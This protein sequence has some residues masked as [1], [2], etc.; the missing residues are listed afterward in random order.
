MK[1]AIRPSFQPSAPTGLPPLYD[2]NDAR[3]LWR[4]RAPANDNLPIKPLAPIV[5]GVM[6]EAALIALATAAFVLPMGA[7]AARFLQDPQKYLSKRLARCGENESP[8]GESRPHWERG[9]WVLFPRYDVSSPLTPHDRKKIIE[10]LYPNEYRDPGPSSVGGRPFAMPEDPKRVDTGALPWEQRNLLWQLP[11]SDSQPAT[12]RTLSHLDAADRMR[13]SPLI[14]GSPHERYLARDFLDSRDVGDKPIPVLPEIRMQAAGDGDRNKRNDAKRF[15]RNAPLLTPEQLE[16]AANDLLPWLATCIENLQHIPDPVAISVLELLVENQILTGNSVTTL[17]ETALD[18]MTGPSDTARVDAMRLYVAT[19]NSG[20]LTASQVEAGVRKMLAALGEGSPKARLN[21]LWGMNVLAPWLV[22]MRNEMEVALKTVAEAAATEG[23]VAL[24]LLEE[25][26]DRLQLSIRT[27]GTPWRSL[28]TNNIR[29]DAIPPR[30]KSLLKRLRIS[31][32]DWLDPMTDLLRFENKRFNEWT[33]KTHI[34]A[35]VD[36]MKEEA[37]HDF[38]LQLMAR[39]LLSPADQRGLRVRLEMAM[40]ANS[41]P[42]RRWAAARARANMLGYGDDELRFMWDAS[43]L[44]VAGNVAAADVEEMRFTLR[45]LDSIYAEANGW[46]QHKV[47]HLRYWHNEILNPQN[48][49]IALPMDA[50]RVVAMNEVLHIAN[51]MRRGAPPIDRMRLGE[52]GRE[53][54]RWA[55]GPPGLVQFRAKAAY[56]QLKTIA[57]GA[58]E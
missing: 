5:G 24:R 26:R 47:G 56:E 25:L 40:V 22:N 33:K 17:S 11:R 32:E 16:R 45:K 27:A 13:V 36:L 12:E 46:A 42:E 50:R 10:I 53:F 41:M 30:V 48:L 39:Q 54:G 4:L 3:N 49:L 20:Y 21:M 31:F 37:F 34:H 57:P 35:F 14:C 55:D 43:Y 6:A 19:V 38:L 9:A 52:I 58:F 44:R 1:L 18:L 29:D 28:V 15:L 2:A 23:I 51:D 8:H 7:A